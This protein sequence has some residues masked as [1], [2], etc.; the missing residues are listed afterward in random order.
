MMMG[1]FLFK[2][3]AREALKGHWQNALVVS[4]F[5][6]VFLTIAQV[7]QTVALQD[8]QA[9]ISR[10]PA[11]ST[12]ATRTG[13]EIRFRFLPEVVC[14]ISAIRSSSRSFMAF[15]RFMGVIG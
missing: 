8:V 2:Q 5:A 15:N 4:F 12:A 1:S 3:K 13:R 10:I 11:I 9:V 7:A 14:I 6:G